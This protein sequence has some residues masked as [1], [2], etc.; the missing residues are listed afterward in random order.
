MPPSAN[1]S[2]SQIASVRRSQIRH[3]KWRHRAPAGRALSARR[4]KPISPLQLL[5]LPAHFLGGRGKFL[6]Y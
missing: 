5:R 1:A 3:E 4:K 6:G 2:I